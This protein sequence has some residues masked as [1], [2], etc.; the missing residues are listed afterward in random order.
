[1]KKTKIKLAVI[2]LGYVG[3]PLAVEFS[4]KRHVI[5]FDIKKKR[6]RELKFAIDRTNE[7]TKKNLK[8]SKK[9][10]LTNSKKNL[11]LANCFIIAVPTPIN[12]FKKPDLKPL[13]DASEMVGKILKKNDIVIYE[14]TVYPGCTEEKCVPILEKFS[15]LKFNKEFFCGYSP[16]RSNPGDKKNK[17]SNIKKV[18]SG[19]NKKIA[20]IVDRL[21]NE[22]I[23]AGT[24]K[25]PSIRIAESSKVIENTQRDLNIAFMNEL[26]NVFDKLNIDFGEVL[27]AAKTKWNFLPFTPGLV[28]GHCIGIDPYYLI[29]K[30]ETSGYKP[31][32][33]SSA[34]N[35]NNKMGDF[36]TKKFIKK[37][38][39][40][41]IKIKNSN[42][43]IMGLTFKENCPDLRNSG[44]STV[45][46]NLT[47]Y[48]CNIDFYDPWTSDDEVKNIYNKKPQKKLKK[49]KYN[50][51]IIAIGHD[52]FKK[53][54]IQYIS[55]IGKKNKVIFDLKS[56]FKKNYSDLRL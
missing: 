33:I 37:M 10:F 3:L 9:L 20:L 16:E 34:R 32:V 48:G 52:Q 27:K 41:S 49:N 39:E 31:K 24:H 29:H 40:K 8:K 18:T 21:Y 43:L 6:I 17:I 46:N 13:L 19:S 26:S 15:N 35:L 54:G 56:L 55:K 5:G 36:I 25:A 28:G 44:I 51:I 42:I 4:K 53:M 14:S 12:N 50:G 7:V 11:E 45:I 38:K 2:G 47:K 22:I 1:M 23:K 30:S